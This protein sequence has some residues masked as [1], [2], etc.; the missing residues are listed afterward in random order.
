MKEL[1]FEAL[2][3]SISVS[4]TEVLGRSPSR[5]INNLVNSTQR[6]YD[7]QQESYGILCESHN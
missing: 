3:N 5:R 2:E 7:H 6:D 1:K 4:N